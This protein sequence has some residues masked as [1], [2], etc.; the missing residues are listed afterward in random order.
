MLPYV[1]LGLLCWFA[2]HESGVH[3]TLAG[4]AFGFLTPAWS[5][6]DPKRF[7]GY[8]R[9]LVAD[10]EAVFSDDVLSHKEY[11]VARSAVRDMRRLSIETEAPLDRLEYGMSGWVTFVVVPVF[12]F[13]NAGLTLPENALTAWVG[14]EVALGVVLGL[15]LGKTIGVFGATWLATKAKV[16]VLPSGTTWRHILGLAVCA[17]IG[18][19]VALFVGELAFSEEDL[20]ESAKLGIFVGSAVSGV[21]G[22][23]LLR[24]GK[25][26]DEADDDTARAER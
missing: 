17:G 1:V 3:A 21:L 16:G 19:T 13:A 2:L 25:V 5:F 23:L 20:G 26:A 12:A 18:F 22:F 4:V 14:D 24:T 7:G 9:G 8:A 10:V 11:D 6:F 15:V